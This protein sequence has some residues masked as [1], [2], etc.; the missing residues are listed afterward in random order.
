MLLE[1]GAY[2]NAPPASLDEYTGYTALQAAAHS[3]SYDIVSCLLD[4]GADIEDSPPGSDESTA[5]TLG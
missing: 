5:L 2:V 1:A 3:G 4:A